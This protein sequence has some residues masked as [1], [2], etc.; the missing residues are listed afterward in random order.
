MKRAS[1]PVRSTLKADI[2]NAT[3]H[4]RYVPKLGN[5]ARRKIALHCEPKAHFLRDPDRLSSRC[6]KAYLG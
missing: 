5:G 2:S 1:Q 4:F 6:P 3:D